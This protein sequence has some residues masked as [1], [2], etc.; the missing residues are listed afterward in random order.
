MAEKLDGFVIVYLDDILIYIEEETQGYVETI[1][2][3][4]NQLQKNG[5]FLNLKKC[6]FY[7]NK[8]WFLAYVI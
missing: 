4:L 6:Y 1:Y 7:K 2:Y 5:L 8:G 3:V